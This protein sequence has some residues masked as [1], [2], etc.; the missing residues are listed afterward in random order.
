M[1]LAEHKKVYMHEDAK[2]VFVVVPIK[3]LE[4]PMLHPDLLRRRFLENS[5]LDD[6]QE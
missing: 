4:N 3:E 1:A 2:S 5:N 6:I